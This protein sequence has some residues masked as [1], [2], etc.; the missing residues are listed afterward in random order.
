[1]ASAELGPDGRS[2]VLSLGGANVAGVVTA[3]DVAGNVEQ[4]PSP[5]VSIDRIDRA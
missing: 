5:A 4:Y 1:V 3:T 2:L